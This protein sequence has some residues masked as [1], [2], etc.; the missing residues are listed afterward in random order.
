MAFTVSHVLDDKRPGD[1]ARFAA[2]FDALRVLAD[3]GTITVD[4]H[5]AV[6]ERS[7]VDEVRVTVW[8]ATHRR[9]AAGW[10]AA[11]VTDNLCPHRYNRVFRS[12]EFAAVQASVA[13]VA[14]LLGRS[15][16]RDDDGS[17]YAALNRSRDATSQG[18]PGGRSETRESALIPCALTAAPRYGRSISA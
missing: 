14:L 1:S 3:G 2:L 15:V 10:A 11:I 18:D 5:V 17:K 8:T 4:F 6:D 12:R 7:D 16:A 13:V 9:G